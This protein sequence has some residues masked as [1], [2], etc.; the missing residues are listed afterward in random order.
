VVPGLGRD[1]FDRG[2]VYARGAK[3]IDGALGAFRMDVEAV[4]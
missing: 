1:D 2:V 4:K 3:R